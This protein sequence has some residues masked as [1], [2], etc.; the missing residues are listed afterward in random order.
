[1]LSLF[2]SRL[3][4]I[5]LFQI[6]FTARG[7][8]WDLGKAAVLIALPVLFLSPVS[9]WIADRFERRWVLVAVSCGRAVLTVG[10]VLATDLWHFYGLIFLNGCLQTLSG[11]SF[12]ALFSDLLEGKELVRAN[13]ARVVFTNLVAVA[14]PPLGAVIYAF[15]GP[16]PVFL[17]DAATF[18]SAGL[19]VASLA[20]RRLQNSTP[21]NGQGAEFM[22][23]GFGDTAKRA[24]GL[25]SGYR[26]ALAFLRTH[27]PF[28]VFVIM[29]TT[30]LAA[31]FA[32]QNALGLVFVERTLG[33]G[34]IHAGVFFGAL[35]VGSM[36]AAI[37]LARLGEEKGGRLRLVAGALLFDG[38]VLLAFSL[39]RW[40]PLTVGLT[41]LLGGIGAVIDVVYVATVQR[42]APR[43][44]QGKIFALRVFALGAVAPLAAGVSTALA[45]VV[46]VYQIFLVSAGVEIAAALLF[47]AYLKISST[48]SSRRL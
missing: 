38:V 45:D 34:V 20:G 47:G 23:S 39:N 31:L 15:W 7:R 4:L 12:L 30:V 2:G 27:R 9:G 18:A 43:N 32:M 26:E 25:W 28:F 24:G 10:Y 17:L 16:V 19:L 22:R 41:V 29:E 8:A 5:V 3:S 1:M 14:G 37:L 42:S 40:F 46:P 36:V 21:P 11:P 48:R 6:V 13:A 33:H 44:L 35:A